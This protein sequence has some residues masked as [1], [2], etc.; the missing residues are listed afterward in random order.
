MKIWTTLLLLII[1]VSVFGQTNKEL[2][3]LKVRDNYISYFKNISVINRDWTKTDKQDSDSLLVLEKKLREVLKGS[4][5]D[6]VV[7]YGKINLETL[8]QDLGFGMLDGLVLNKYS[9][10]S[11]QI[12]V[13]S[14]PLFFDCFKSQQINSID[15]LTPRQLDDI[16]TALVSDAHATVFYSENISSNKSNQVY[17]GIV[18][19]AQDIGRFTP[20]II[21]ALISNGNYIYII[22]KYLDKPIKEM[23]DCQAIYDSIYSNSQEYFKSYQSSNLQDTAAFNKKIELEEI[24]W[25][26]YCECYQKNFRNDKQFEPILRQIK[27]IV[28]YVERYT[29]R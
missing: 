20:D 22:Q 16:L 24:A 18:T 9:S 2:E 28:Q 4:K 11:L 17:G 13:T 14:K 12:F 23:K 29:S 3:Y 19:I 26:K 5:I 6:S 27:N 10:N 15:N 7:K 21:F 1:S 8:Q 25:K